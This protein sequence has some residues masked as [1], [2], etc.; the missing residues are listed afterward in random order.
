M[1]KKTALFSFFAVFLFVYLL[2]ITGC[3]TSGHVGAD[4]ESKQ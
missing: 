3:Q 4:C 1:K 2:Q